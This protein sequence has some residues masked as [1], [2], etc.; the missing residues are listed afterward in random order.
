MIQQ[1]V[2]E[3]KIYSRFLGYFYLRLGSHTSTV[4]PADLVESVGHLT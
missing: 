1:K 3:K 4:L 2:F